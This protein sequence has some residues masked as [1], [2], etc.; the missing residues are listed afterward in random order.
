M[1]NNIKSNELGNEVVQES[2]YFSYQL[3]KKLNKELNIYSHVKQ[4]N[5]IKI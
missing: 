3:H 4:K 2:D 1:S 5:K